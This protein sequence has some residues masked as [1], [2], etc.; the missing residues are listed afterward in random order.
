MYTQKELKRAAAHI[1][2]L[3]RENGIA[4][5]DMRA[6]M[7]AAMDAGR[8]KRSG[9]S[10]PMGGI[11]IYRAGTDCRRVRIMGIVLGKERMIQS[12]FSPCFV[13]ILSA[14]AK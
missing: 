9:R 3:A 8:K 2:R 7:K 5:E 10:S 14:I 12:M 4:E 6:E 13:L 1:R 11:E